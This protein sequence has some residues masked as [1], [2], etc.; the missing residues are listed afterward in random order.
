MQKSRDCA[1]SISNYYPILPPHWTLR[2][3]N[4]FKCRLCCFEFAAKIFWQHTH[5]NIIA[6]CFDY[7]RIVGICKHENWGSVSS[8]DLYHNTYPQWIIPAQIPPRYKLTQSWN[9]WILRKWCHVLR[10][11][12]VENNVNYI[13]QKRKN[14]NLNC[15]CCSKGI[16]RVI[17][18]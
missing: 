5:K 8:S 15:Y 10:N 12:Q 6:Q 16:G 11:E 3:V 2:T 14:E 7:I 4:R 1:A 17:W 18:R 9:V 13:N